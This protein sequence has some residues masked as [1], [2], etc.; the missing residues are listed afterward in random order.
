MAKEI[1]IASGSGPNTDL[2]KNDRVMLV[3]DRMRLSEEY[4]QP[5]FD[6]FIDN[7]KHYYLRVIDDLIS[8]EN[9]SYPFYSQLMLPIT[10]Q[11]VETILPRMFSRLPSFRITTE[12]DNDESDEQAL[13]NLIRYQMNHPYLLDDP[14]LLRMA[15]ACK[16]M[17]I[18]GNAWGM[19]PWMLKEVEVEEWQPYS[20]ELGISE[21][22]WDNY[23]KI[24]FYG[25]QLDWG[26]V[27]VKKPLI[28][29]P[30]FQHK[31]IFQVFPDPKKKWVSQLG[32]VTVQ[33]FMTLDEIMEAVNL[34]PGKYQHIDELRALKVQNMYSGGEGNTKGQTNYMD[35]LAGMF[36]SSD[37]S[38]KDTSK[39]QAQFEVLTHMTPGGM[40]IVVNRRLCIRTG[41]NPNGDG[42]L[43]VILMKDIPVPHELYAWGEPDP[44][45]KIEDQ[46]SDQANMRNDSV[47]Y[48]LLRMY[49]LDPTALVDGEEF[50]PEPGNVVQ[51]NDLNGLEPLDVGST[52]ASAYKEFSEWT[53]IIQSTS[54]V[55]DYATGQ[56]G[57]NDTRG[58]IELL[59][60]A[61]NARF[62]FKLRLFEEIGI[63][64]IGSM[65]INRNMR[66][67]DGAQN[68]NTGK[69]KITVT[70]DSVRKLRGNINFVVE[71]GSTESV[72][73]SSEMERWD[74]V[75]T[76]MGEGKP[77]FANLTQEA[78]DYVAT[79]ILGV[80][81]VPDPSKIVQHPEAPTTPQATDA[82]GNPLPGAVEEQ[83]ADL[84][85]GQ[86][87]IDAGA[88]PQVPSAQVTPDANPVGPDQTPTQPA[89]PAYN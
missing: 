20:D 65:Y 61:A 43:G 40:D 24:Q 1:I 73:R 71:T 64:A 2:S 5:Y 30:V 85:A 66:F 79:K 44:I 38:T 25:A 11:V 77:P 23:E 6:R 32:Y 19:V 45:K 88:S 26:L 69:E 28:D 62:F 46:M 82:Q 27:K 53:Q 29:A 7:Y 42:K 36:G 47:F 48:D 70:V 31:S 21:P 3:N 67:F 37:W 49:K 16:E 35:Q 84:E 4:T 81:Q 9:Q 57:A 54:G 14:M 59:Q 58:G 12:D 56:G 34:A 89:V 68:I 80:L 8:K 52:Q 83:N 15:S 41:S 50:I 78:Y 60:Q 51:M 74:K 87:Q 22:S 86:T 18:T 63:R 33:E 72:D 10:Y 39:D 17:F 75:L 55:N 76:L 13:E